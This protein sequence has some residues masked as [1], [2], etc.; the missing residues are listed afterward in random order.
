[1]L[2]D[3]AAFGERRNRARLARR[4]CARRR[5]A[6]VRP[7]RAVFRLPV[8]SSVFRPARR[9]NSLSELAIRASRKSGIT[10]QQA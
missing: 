4:A 8:T 1:L 7:V 10:V 2:H 5:V 3:T 9:R 6:S